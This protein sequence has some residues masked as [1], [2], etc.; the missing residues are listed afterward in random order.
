MSLTA[1]KPKEWKAKKE[2]LEA[3]LKAE[4]NHLNQG[5]I[6]RTDYNKIALERGHIA[7]M[8]DFTAGELY[9]WNKGG[10]NSAGGQVS[11]RELREVEDTIWKWYEEHIKG[12]A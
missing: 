11:V 10:N 5:R 3:A 4:G 8:F 2:A 9:V 7:A 6:I 12:W 1:Y